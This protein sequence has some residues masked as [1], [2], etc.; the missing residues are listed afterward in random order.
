M[1]KTFE[2]L[3][4]DLVAIIEERGYCTS[5]YERYEFGEL[6]EYWERDNDGVWHNRTQR[7]LNK[8]KSK[9]MLRKLLAQLRK[10]N[11]EV[12]SFNG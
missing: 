7:E 9:E 12:E 3:H 6:K 1:A 11:K 5:V 10:A 2:E 4:P 8:A